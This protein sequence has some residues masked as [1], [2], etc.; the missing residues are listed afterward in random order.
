MGHQFRETEDLKITPQESPSMWVPPYLV[1][2]STLSKLVFCPCPELLNVPCLTGWSHQPCSHVCFKFRN[3]PQ[4]YFSSTPTSSEGL[5]VSSLK[6]FWSRILFISPPPCP[7]SVLH[8]L[9]SGFLQEH[10]T[11]F[12]PSLPIHIRILLK[13]Q[14]LY[15][16]SCLDSSHL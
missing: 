1:N 7:D 2:L 4:V 10:L 3:H 16:T 6:L 15:V 13:F 14:I 8:H 11:Y 12:C 5:L 9:S